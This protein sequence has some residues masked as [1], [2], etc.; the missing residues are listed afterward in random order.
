MPH[1]KYDT[2]YG[3]SWALFHML[4]FSVDRKGQFKQFLRALSDGLTEL[5]AAERAFGD[6]KVLVDASYGYK[7][8]QQAETCLDIDA[9]SISI[10][11]QIFIA[12]AMEQMIRDSNAQ[13]DD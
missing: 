7:A 11:S 1:W 9:N 13:P 3:Q 2:F 10:D 8:K 6:L 5:K 4:Q 12:L